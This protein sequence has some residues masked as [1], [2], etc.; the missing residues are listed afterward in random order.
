MATP[1]TSPPPRGWASTSPSGAD[2][3]PTASKNLLHEL[4]VARIHSDEQGIGL[5]DQQLVEM[6]TLTP[7]HVLGWQAALG[8][9]SRAKLADITVVKGRTQD[10]YRHLVDA[11][12]SDILLVNSGVTTT[13]HRRCLHSPVEENVDI[14]GNTRALHLDTMPQPVLGPIALGEAARLHADALGAHARGRGDR[15]T[16]AGR[17][18]RRGGHRRGR[19]AGTWS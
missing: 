10:P 15:S 17:R 4:K 6:V 5:T 13:G 1:P 9:S 3:S 16:S 12:E 19:N 14:A 18:P 7:A 8:S 2:W 11:V